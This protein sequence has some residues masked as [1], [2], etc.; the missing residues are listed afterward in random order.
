MIDGNSGDQEKQCGDQ[1]PEMV[2]VPLAETPPVTPEAPLVEPR[3]VPEQAPSQIA[4]PG[5]QQNEANDLNTFEKDM[6]K[7]E[8]SVVRLTIIGIAV[9]AITGAIFYGQFCEMSNQTGLLNSQAQQAVAD[10]VEASKK[11]D[12]QIKAVEANVAAIKEQMLVGERA[13]LG[14]GNARRFSIPQTGGFGLE[15][16]LVNTGKTPAFIKS[17]RKTSR[18]FD[19]NRSELPIHPPYGARDTLL[20]V[21]P[22]FPTQL[23]PFQ[24]SAPTYVEDDMNAIRNERKT[25][26]FYG[27]IEYNDVFGRSHFTQFCYHWIT[28]W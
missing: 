25:L 26:N 10:S 27:V 24:Q 13:W 18:F 8:R 2:A 3:P 1:T 9:A 14:F 23:L 19:G 22:L 21:Q 16:D 4:T 15:F 28:T 5:P 11:A 6:S 12:R 17:F 20:G 7:F